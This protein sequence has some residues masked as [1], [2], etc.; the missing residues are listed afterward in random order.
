VQAP[1]KY[2]IS[3]AGRSWHW[4]GQAPFWVWLEGDPGC[5]SATGYSVA[6]RL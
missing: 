1:T 2:E 3:A 5:G 4:A 6:E